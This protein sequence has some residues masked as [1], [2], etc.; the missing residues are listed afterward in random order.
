MLS[1]LMVLSLISEN[2]TVLGLTQLNGQ[3][4][5]DESGLRSESRQAGNYS[6]DSIKEFVGNNDRCSLQ[7][8]VS[9]EYIVGS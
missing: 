6:R 4:L 1:M 5:P 7:K 9:P 3:S 8:C 2:S